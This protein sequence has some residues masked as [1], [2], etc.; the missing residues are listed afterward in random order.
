L[1]RLDVLENRLNHHVCVGDAV[2][3]KVH[4]QACGCSGRSRRVFQAFLKEILRA[5]K[6][7]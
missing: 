2:A 5:V 6:G 4:C 7:G 3:F 1:L